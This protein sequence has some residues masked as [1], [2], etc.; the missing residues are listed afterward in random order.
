[1]A[2]RIVLR[3]KMEAGA[4]EV[5]ETS[6]KELQEELECCKTGNADQTI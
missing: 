6:L 4:R 2:M 5:L 3:G 1:M